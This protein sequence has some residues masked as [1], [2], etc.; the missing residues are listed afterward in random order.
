M[1]MTQQHHLYHNFSLFD[2]EGP[3]VTTEL[4]RKTESLFSESSG[5]NIKL[6]KIMKE[7]KH[8][9]DLSSLKTPEINPEIES[10]QQYQSN[11]T[12]FK[13]KLCDQSYFNIIKYD[14]LNFKSFRC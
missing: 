1:Q 3:S 12:L 9:A 13:S 7:Y 8:P 11:T 14:K 10:F 5:E 2:E 6:Q 4:A